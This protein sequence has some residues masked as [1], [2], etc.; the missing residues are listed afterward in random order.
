MTMIDDTHRLTV[1]CCQVNVES[2][3][4]TS[5]CWTQYRL[6]GDHLTLLHRSLVKK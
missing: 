1:F 5:L 4:G 6:Q 3:A 2:Q